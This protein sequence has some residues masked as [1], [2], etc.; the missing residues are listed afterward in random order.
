MNILEAEDMVKGLPDQVLFQIAQNPPPNIPQFLAVSEVQRRQDMRQRYQA[1][2]PE[3]TV[4]DQILQSGIAAA[5]G[6][7]PGAGQPPPMAPPGAAPP[8]A[9]MQQPMTGAPMAQMY[10]GGRVRMQEGRTVPSQADIEAAMKTPPYLRTPEQRALLRSV[11]EG[12]AIGRLLS[13][14]SRAVES[15]R[16]RAVEAGLPAAAAAMT[17][18]PVAP[19]AAPPQAPPTPSVPPP[20]EAA[21]A[22]PR[23]GREATTSEVLFPASATPAPVEAPVTPE[24]PDARQQRLT[25]FMSSLPD[26][27]NQVQGMTPPVGGVNMADLQRFA[28]QQSDYMSPDFAARQDALLKQLETTA[29]ARKAEDLAAAQRALTEAEAPIQSAQ[30]EARKAAI[31]STLMRL[32]AG[33]VAGD[34]AAGLA[35]ATESVENI[36]TRAREQA[37]AERRAARQEF[38]QAER[39]AV[40]GERS[41]ADAAFQMQAQRVTADENKQRDF[42]RDQKQFAQWTYGIMREQGRD[43]RQAYND[44]IRLSIGIAQAIDQAIRDEDK[45]NRITQNQYTSTFGSVFKEVLNAVKESE[46]VDPETGESVAPTADQ[47]LEAARNKTRET[48]ASAGITA[49]GAQSAPVQVKTQSEL[50]NLP[51]GTRYIYVGPG[52]DNKVRIKP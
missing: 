50:A 29:A 3:Q 25:G 26:V 48:L 34:P 24:L 23:L 14:L 11:S 30:D 44:S 18:A 16:P 4:K 5:G 33:L 20:M 37:S 47:L 12:S 39:E 45:E 36:L 38:R 43:Q 42:V 49:A 22:R 46:F 17:P 15:V 27:F 9:P 19:P 40:R 21:V 2:Q 8:G 10:M 6:P 28:P 32:G 7:P 51:A 35:G 52:S 31:S 13:P 41:M 1:K